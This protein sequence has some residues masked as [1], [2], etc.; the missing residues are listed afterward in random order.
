MIVKTLIVS[1]AIY[2]V[3][4]TAIQVALGRGEVVLPVVSFVILVV[5]PI[6]TTTE[7]EQFT[8]VKKLPQ[9]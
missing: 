6:I 4:K 1:I 3:L 2:S 5:S 9:H 8:P 7:V